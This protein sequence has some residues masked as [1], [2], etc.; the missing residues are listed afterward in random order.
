[1]PDSL[2]TS[3]RAETS[4][5]S[6]PGSG[7]TASKPTTLP[8]PEAATL[9]FAFARDQQVLLEI[10]AGRELIRKEILTNA[11]ARTTDLGIEILDLQFKR[12]NYVEEVRRKV[13]DRMI[14]E[15]ERIADRFRSE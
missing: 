1:M 13:Y 15:R 5:R 11:Q 10:E 9:P 3:P 7:S 4:R 14:A 12:I 2:M 8:D 6:P